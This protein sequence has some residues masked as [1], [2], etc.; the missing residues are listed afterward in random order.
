M[1]LSDIKIAVGKIVEGVQSNE[2]FGKFKYKVDTH[3]DEDVRCNVNIRNF[4]AMIV[5]EPPAF[6]GSDLGASPVELV[7]GAL[8]SCQEIMYA[9]LA[10][11]MDIELEEVKVELV[12]DLDVR[13]LLGMDGV[14][15]GFTKIEF[16]THIKAPTAT[17]DQL[18]QLM[19]AVENQCP[20]LDMLTTKVEISG[21]AMGNGERL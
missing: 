13:G 11:V 8:G 16:Q 2:S 19:N 10:S 21:S 3:W 18:S 12:G 6:G 20:V 17:K 1:A 9:A 15:P 4:P 7:L 14:R 5:D